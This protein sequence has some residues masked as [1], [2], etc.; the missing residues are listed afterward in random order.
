LLAAVDRP[1]TGTVTVGGVPV[2]DLPADLLRRKVILVTQEHHVFRETLRD[3]LMVA[4][5]DDRLREALRTV[6]ADWAPDL[7]TDLGEHPPTGVQAQQ[8]AL[9]RAVRY[10]DHHDG[11]AHVAAQHPALSATA[12][13]VRGVRAGSQHSVVG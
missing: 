3:N 7:D 1:H 13:T 11:G 12:G 2:A 6:G 9:A 4:A 5:P 8:L 10:L